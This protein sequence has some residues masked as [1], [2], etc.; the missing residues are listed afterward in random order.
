MLEAQ[1]RELLDQLGAIDRALAAL[2]SAG[3]A[4]EDPRPADPEVP[5]DE[6]PPDEVPADK[7]MSTVVPRRVKPRR[8]LSDSHKQA[9]VV[10]TRKAREARDAAKGLAR[11][12]PGDSFVPA[13]GTRGD[14]QPPRLV[15]RP[16]NH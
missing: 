9:L 8:V 3:V 5:S 14:R 15:K 13:I 1:R 10:S 7:T 12:M 11:E 2:H 16:T 6:V 4:V